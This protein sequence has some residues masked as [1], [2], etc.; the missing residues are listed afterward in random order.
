MVFDLPGRVRHTAVR[1]AVLHRA[2]RQ[3]RPSPGDEQRRSAEGTV[4]ARLSDRPG[5]IWTPAAGT[6][7]AGLRRG[8][9]PAS[10]QDQGGGA[11]S[12]AP[13]RHVSS[14]PSSG[15]WACGSG[16]SWLALARGGAVGLGASLDDG[17]AEGEPVDVRHRLFWSAASSSRH[18]ASWSR[19]RTRM[20]VLAP[21]RRPQVAA[22]PAGRA[23]ESA[24]FALFFHGDSLVSLLGDAVTPFALA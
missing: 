12:I 9:C 19:R 7:S 6:A 16:T 22:D 13:T 4:P 5:S 11:V 15:A 1:G 17:G 23:P 24:S 20:G 14:S 18:V 8:T 3:R 21:G 10:T 2:E